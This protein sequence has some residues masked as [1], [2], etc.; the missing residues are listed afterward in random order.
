MDRT[1][2]LDNRMANLERKFE[3]SRL[4]E[5]I[6]ASVYE[7]LLPMACQQPPREHSQAGHV[8]RQPRQAQA[9]RVS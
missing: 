6:L 4:S 5:G 9:R 3:R 1:A 2:T 7:R 8:D